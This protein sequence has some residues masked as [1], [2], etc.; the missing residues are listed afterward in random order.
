MELRHLRYFVAVAEELHFGRAATRLHMAQPPLSQQIRRLEQ[1]IGVR[2]LD[3]SQPRRVRLTEAGRIFLAEARRI[4]E[5]S[6]RAVQTAQSVH[7]GEMGH[8]SVGFVGSAT[9]RILPS[10]LRIFRDQ[11]PR[12]DVSLRPLTTAQ[13]VQALHDAQIDVG[14]VRPPVSSGEVRLVTLLRETHVVALPDVHP[15]AA[16]RRVP[17][18]RLAGE[19]FVLLARP[20]IPILYDQ[21]IDL[22]RG[23]GFC[24]TVTQ[25]A[26]QL[27]T[28]VCLVAAGVG[29]AFVPESVRGLRLPGVVYRPLL[30]AAPSTELALAWRHEDVS[31]TLLAFTDLVGHMGGEL[32]RR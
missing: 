21:I 16:L 30:E 12:V 10:A 26:Q 18:T 11:F 25:E 17:V 6:H 9:Y 13:Q 8:L 7:R 2:L 28:V 29:V 15:L 24:P 32:A 31:A 27:Q 5:Q 19:R 23:A 3:R 1:E 4:L 14:F 22:C 20:M